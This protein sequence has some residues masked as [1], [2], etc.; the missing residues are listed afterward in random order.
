MAMTANKRIL[1]VGGLA[2]EVNEKILQVSEQ[3][4]VCGI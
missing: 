3:E 4:G 2:E 1:Y